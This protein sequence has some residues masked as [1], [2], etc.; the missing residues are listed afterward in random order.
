MTMKTLANLLEM[1]AGLQRDLGLQDALPL[2]RD[3]I[4][5]IGMYMEDGRDYVKTETL[6]SHPLLA[7]VPR[8]SL[9][10]A[11]NSLRTRG[12]VAV[13]EGYRSGRYV[14]TEALSGKQ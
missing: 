11:L 1:V 2:E 3:I 5:I 8:A 4:A 10:R 7:S 12:F 6:I 9:Y 13:A 14:L